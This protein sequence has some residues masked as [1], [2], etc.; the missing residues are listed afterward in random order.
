MT[1]QLAVCDAATARAA[2]V[3]DLTARPADRLIPSSV[4]PAP[5]H[6][7]SPSRSVPPT[8]APGRRRDLSLTLSLTLASA[9]LT[10]TL[11]LTLSLT[12]TLAL[13]LSLSLEPQ[14]HPSSA[15]ASPSPSPSPSP[16]LLSL[17]P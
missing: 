8:G 1:V 9:H 5:R 2:S 15:S 12:L 14:P 11:S 7:G 16:S 13:S 10:L 17:A 4:P 3:V 6:H